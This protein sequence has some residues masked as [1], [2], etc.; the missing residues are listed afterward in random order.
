MWRIRE[1]RT[2]NI[3]IRS[4]GSIQ[5]RLRDHLAGSLAV[6]CG[7]GKPKT[8]FGHENAQRVFDIVANAHIRTVTRI[9]PRAAMNAST[10]VSRSYP[11]H[12]SA[13]CLVQRASSN[14]FEARA[15]VLARHASI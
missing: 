7:W 4:Q 1:T 11:G 3:L 15:R 14:A 12:A 13:P 9:K 2:P 5:L 6:K 8:H 10:P